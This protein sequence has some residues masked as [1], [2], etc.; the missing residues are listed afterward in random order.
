MA[1]EDIFRL[2]SI[3]RSGA[4]DGARHVFAGEVSS[5]FEKPCCAMEKWFLCVCYPQYESVIDFVLC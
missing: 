3:D 5:E 1:P 2:Y 4:V